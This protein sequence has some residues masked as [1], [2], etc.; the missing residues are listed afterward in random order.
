[1]ASI[2]APE[3]P[4]FVPFTKAERI[5]QLNEIDKSITTLLHSAGLALQTLTTTSTQ[6]SSPQVQNKREA[7]QEKSNTYLR[8]LQ[9]IDVR[10]R[11][12]IYGLEEEDIIAGAKTKTKASEGQE[13]VV[14]GAGGKDETQ[15]SIG[16]GG[17]GKLD[18]GWLNSRSGSV[19][20]K[21]ESELWERAKSYLESIEKSGDNGTNDREGDHDMGG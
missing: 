6:T 21:M 17:M 12:Q 10:L 4:A 11:R 14:Q 19:G 8:T 13:G 20:M 18:I 3:D 7:F 1:M 9:S 5:Q 16:E 15:I 2:P